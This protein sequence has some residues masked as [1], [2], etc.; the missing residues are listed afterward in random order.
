MKKAEAH[1]V[2]PQTSEFMNFFKSKGFNVHDPRFGTWVEK[3]TH[4]KWSYEYNAYWRDYIRKYP[5]ASPEQ[6]LNYA[7]T[8]AKKYNFKVNF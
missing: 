6:V 4:A 7:R 1:H 8:L 5:D 3:Q 2:L